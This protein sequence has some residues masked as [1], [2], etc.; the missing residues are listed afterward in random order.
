VPALGFDD[1]KAV[2]I[3]TGIVAF[4]SRQ[5]FALGGTEK[6]EVGDVMA[7]ASAGVGLGAAVVPAKRVQHRFDDVFFGLRLVPCAG[8]VHVVIDPA[9]GIA[10][11]QEFLLRVQPPARL[12]DALAQ[13]IG[14][15][16]E[17]VH[18]LSLVSPRRMVAVR[19]PACRTG[20]GSSYTTLDLSVV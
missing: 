17:A 14:R 12:A 7:T 5:A 8:V 4:G 10:E 6:Q 1:G 16:Q 18:A 19:Q 9:D 11:G 20:V 15:K 2:S 13:E 3:A